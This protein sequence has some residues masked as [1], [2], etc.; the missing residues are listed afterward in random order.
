MM[1]NRTVL[2]T[3]MFLEIRKPQIPQFSYSGVQALFETAGLDRGFGFLEFE[4]E[5]VC[6]LLLFVFTKLEN[7]GKPRKH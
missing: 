2:L 3:F 5:N 4:E 1:M 6:F 7:F